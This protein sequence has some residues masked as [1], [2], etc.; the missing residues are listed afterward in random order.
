MKTAKGFILRLFL[1]VFVI[2]S[3]WSPRAA[4]RAPMVYSPPS[5]IS[6]WLYWLTASGARR[7]PY[8]LCASGHRT[9]GCTAFCNEPGYPCERGQ[10]RAYPYSNNPVTIPIETDY[11][12]DV[13]PKEVSVALCVYD[14]LDIAHL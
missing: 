7:E 1:C 11:L 10:D 14:G 3:P 9:W 8:T 2:L 4:A 5:Q 12:L 13:A 6:V